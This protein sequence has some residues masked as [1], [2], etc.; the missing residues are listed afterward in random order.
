MLKISLIAAAALCAAAVPAL[1]QE[2]DADIVQRAVS[3]AD[4]DLSSQAGVAAF[5]QRIEKAVTQV[6]GSVDGYDLH[7]QRRMETCRNDARSK[8]EVTRNALVASAQSQKTKSV[9]LAAK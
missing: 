2:L 7:A 9:V 3:Y 1:A 4:L 8:I 5:D 6:C